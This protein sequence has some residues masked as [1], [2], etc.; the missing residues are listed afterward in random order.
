MDWT[1]DE[2]KRQLTV[3]YE[4]SHAA[5]ALWAFSLLYGPTLISVAQ[6][7]KNLPAMQETW[8]FGCLNNGEVEN[9]ID[10][11]IT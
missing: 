8:V 5:A 11:N 9:I 4:Q 10:K 3:L 7:V 2:R 1:Q 6:L